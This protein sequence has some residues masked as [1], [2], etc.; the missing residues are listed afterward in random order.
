MGRLAA[1]HHCTLLINTNEAILKESLRKPELHIETKATRSVR[2]A[3]VNLHDFNSEITPDNLLVALANA[4]VSSNRI[5]V[6]EP[7]KIV[8]ATEANFADLDKLTSQYRSWEWCFGLT[9]KFTVKKRFR[10]EMEQFEVN[11]MIEKGRIGD[12]FVSPAANID[13]DCLK[14]KIYSEDCLEEVLQSNKLLTHQTSV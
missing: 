6:E 4:Y 9:P 10:I 1:Y 13:F 5:S 3:I 14:G 8:E 2:S 11:L 12:V 7:I